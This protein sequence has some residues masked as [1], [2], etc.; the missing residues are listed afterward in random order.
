MIVCRRILYSENH[1]I[2][3]S[4]DYYFIRAVLTDKFLGYW[5]YLGKRENV[6]HVTVI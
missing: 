3:L 1:S 5:D 6:L 4:Y 2:K